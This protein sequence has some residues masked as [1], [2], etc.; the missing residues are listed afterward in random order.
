MAKKIYKCKCVTINNDISIEKN[1]RLVT[2]VTWEDHNCEM[3]GE[4]KEKA[5]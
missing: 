1:T 4:G 3:G 2:G 5:N